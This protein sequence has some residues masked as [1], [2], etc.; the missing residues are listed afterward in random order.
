MFNQSGKTPTKSSRGQEILRSTRVTRDLGDNRSK[1]TVA[2]IETTATEETATKTATCTDASGKQ[3]CQKR[4][5]RI[6]CI[7]S[8]RS[9]PADLSRQDL[10]QT[11]STRSP[12]LLDLSSEAPPE[13][14][15]QIRRS[16]RTKK[17][18]ERY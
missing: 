3:S 11:E 7:R 9:S 5:N 4:G 10:Q 16:Q 13:L 18:P 14:E 2:V 6:R 17:K 15:R 8:I 1:E 12:A